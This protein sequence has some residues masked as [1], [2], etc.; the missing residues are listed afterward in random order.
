MFIFLSL[1]CKCFRF[2]VARTKNCLSLWE[3]V[4]SISMFLKL[5]RHYSHVT[6][7]NF[8]WTLFYESQYDFVEVNTFNTEMGVPSPPP[9]R[10]P[11]PIT[12]KQLLHCFLKMHY[13]TPFP[14]PRLLI[15]HQKWQ[16]KYKIL[17]TNYYLHSYTTYKQSNSSKFTSK[18]TA[19][20]S[21]IKTFINS[22]VC[23]LLQ[24]TC[25]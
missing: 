7:G 3:I 14:S 10:Y 24:R 2:F 12:P 21:T 8:L 22:A 18:L 20:C 13:C 9:P 4:Q 5:F 25:C 1:N 17:T 16:V 15:F 19:L 6:R 23:F 11:P